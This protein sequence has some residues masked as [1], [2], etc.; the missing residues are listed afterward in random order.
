MRVLF[1]NDVP[2]GEGDS[3]PQASSLAVAVDAA[4]HAVRAI[5]LGPAERTRRGEFNSAA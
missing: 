2:L 5:D 1:A 3:G 4:G